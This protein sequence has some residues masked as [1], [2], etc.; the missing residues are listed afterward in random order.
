MVWL[1][2]ESCGWV[3]ETIP[4]PEEKPAE[5]SQLP[6]ASSEE[7]RSHMECEQAGSEGSSRV[8]RS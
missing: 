1:A 5:G 6:L 8:N 7:L 3:R 2:E 4:V